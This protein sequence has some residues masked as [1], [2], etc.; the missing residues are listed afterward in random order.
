MHRRAFLKAAGAA[1]AL[2]VSGGAWYAYDRGVFSVGEGP[3][4]EPWKDWRGDGSE[5][6]LALV[7][8]RS[9]PRA[10]TTRSLGASEW[11]IHSWNFISTR[12]GMSARLTPFCAKSISE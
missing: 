10:R 5:G 8:L 6:P 1:T 3:A 7:D 2:S 4:Y 11:R 9:W 12:K